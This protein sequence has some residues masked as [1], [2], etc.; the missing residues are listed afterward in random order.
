[1]RVIPA[2]GLD[3]LELA[4]KATMKCKLGR[5]GKILLTRVRRT[6]L[7]TKTLT[8]TYQYPVKGGDLPYPPKPKS[9]VNYPP[10]QGDCKVTMGTNCS[11]ER[12]NVPLPTP[13]YY[14]PPR[15]IRIGRGTFG[16]TRHPAIQG[17]NAAPGVRGG[18]GDNLLTRTIKNPWCSSRGVGHAPA[19]W[20]NYIT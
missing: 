5:L 15:L 2:R 20:Q 19:P 18:V 3:H 14:L 13:G 7:E 6:S 12:I 4:H 10:L 8:I 1:M 11:P 16:P 9:N 17:E